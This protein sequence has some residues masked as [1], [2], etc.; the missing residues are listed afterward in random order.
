MKQG[1]FLF[2]NVLYYNI[3]LIKRYIFCK[4]STLI[5]KVLKNL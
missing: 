5:K 4:I 2:N 1:I 3:F